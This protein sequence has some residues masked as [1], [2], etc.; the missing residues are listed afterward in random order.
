M[1]S[2]RP[3]QRRHRASLHLDIGNR[4]Y[5]MLRFLRRNAELITS[6][7]VVLSLVLG[8]VLAFIII[9]GRTS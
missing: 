2:Q 1:V 9:S 7:C 6:V 5:P 8:S 3:L 4:L